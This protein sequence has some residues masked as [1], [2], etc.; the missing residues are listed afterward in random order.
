M[1]GVN[2]PVI[3]ITWK[4]VKHAR[5]FL[6][7]ATAFA[8][9]DAGRRELVALCEELKFSCGVSACRGRDPVFAG[10]IQLVVRLAAVGRNWLA[11]GQNRRKQ[12]NLTASAAGE[13]ALPFHRAVHSGLQGLFLMRPALQNA[14]QNR[15]RHHHCRKP[16][17]NQKIEHNSCSVLWQ[18]GHSRVQADSRRLV[19]SRIRPS[20]SVLCGSTKTE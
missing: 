15:R 13:S 2:R 1:V 20:E 3:Q 17:T 7:T 9:W 6:S 8:A 5:G 16:G 10:M 4:E 12:H 14:G 19:S 18:P 11:V